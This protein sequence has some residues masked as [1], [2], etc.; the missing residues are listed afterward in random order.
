MPSAKQVIA[1][2][3]G[4]VD[5]DD[6]RVRTIALQMA[7]T[8]SR[9]GHANTAKALQKIADDIGRKTPVPKATAVASISRPRGALDGLMTETRS[10]VTLDDM[11]LTPAISERLAGLVAQQQ[12]RDM[13]RRYGQS[14]NSRLL[15]VGPPGSGKTL[16]ASALAG[17][18]HL[19]L[20]TIRLDTVITRFLGETA[21][22]LRL[23]FDQINQMRG[24]YLFDEFDAIGGRRSADNDVGEIRRVLNSFLQFMEESNATDS[25]VVAAT[26]HPELLDRA[27]L[28]RFD[29]IIEYGLPSADEA[30][31]LIQSRLGKLKPRTG[32]WSRV[33]EQA[34]GLSYG[35]L[36]RAADEAVKVAIM[37]D[38][39][40]ARV[41]DVEVALQS[42]RAM[43]DVMTDVFINS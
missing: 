32:S 39:Q 29:D 16:T 19:P 31:A 15:L 30:V 11:T 6:E 42:R 4:H 28:R 10:R 40:K 35:E 20:F 8:E 9:Q 38:R 7:A 41:A 2:L 26:N 34:D 5:G 21:A 37:A 24:V 17:T 33:A 1:M 23:V 13:L 27:L 18:L 25:V 3:A 43:R 22:K 12:R 36:A 14:P